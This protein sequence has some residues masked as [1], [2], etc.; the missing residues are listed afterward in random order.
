MAKKRSRLAQ[1]SPLTPAQER[2]LESLK[3]LRAVAGFYLAGGS[4][5]ALRLKH[6]QSLDHDF[7][8]PKAFQPQTLLARLPKLSPRM[9]VLSREAGTLTVSAGGVKASFFRY[10]YPLLERTELVAGKFPVASLRDIGLMKLTAILDRG[11]RKDFVDL[12]HIL[13]AGLSLESLLDDLPRKFPGIEYPKYVF[14][15]A[16]VYFADADAE[17]LV[18][19][20]PT[21][22]WKK[23]QEHFR[24]E[25]ASV[26]L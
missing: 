22:S 5:L 23:L 25:V 21:P 13:S 7:F 18:L 3:G 16:L 24:A 9:K 2:Y 1:G 26:R 6:R 14:L 12:Y 4:G 15:K 8:T 19:L 20:K 17:P 10:P 11:A